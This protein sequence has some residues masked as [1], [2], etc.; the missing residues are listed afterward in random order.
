MPLES[1]S[2][3]N[4]CLA[5]FSSSYCFASTVISF[6]NLFCISAASFSFM[7]NVFSYCAI[8][9]EIS[10]LLAASFCNCLLKCA[11]SCLK[12]SSSCSCSATSAGPA[13]SYAWPVSRSMI[14]CFSKTSD[15]NSALV[16]SS[17]ASLSC[18]AN[19]LACLPSS[20]LCNTSSYF[21]CESELDLIEAN[22]ALILCSFCIYC[23][24]FLFARFNSDSLSLNFF[25]LWLYSKSKLVLRFWFAV[26]YS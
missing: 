3:I 19:I 2:L 8:L 20:S 17:A 12:R 5:A 21:Y 4:F 23:F 18:M 25:S 6:W 1:Y 10:L 11:F 26:I 13:C 14:R 24:N 22:S 7:W 15:F 9:A 16:A